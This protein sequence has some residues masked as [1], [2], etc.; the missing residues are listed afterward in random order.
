M[1]NKFVSVEEAVQLVRDEVTLCLT[2]FAS[3]GAPEALLQGL[4]QRFLDTGSPRQLTLLFG[5]ATGDFSEKYG[6]NH[7]AHEGLLKRV[8]GAHFNAAPKVGE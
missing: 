3:H 2:G 1:R 8:V 7:M 6:V 4:E 5:V